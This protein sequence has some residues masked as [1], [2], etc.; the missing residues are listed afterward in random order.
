MSSKE[1]VEKSLKEVQDSREKQREKKRLLRELNGKWQ[2][3]KRQKDPLSAKTVP[4]FDSS[5]PEMLRYLKEHGYVVVKSVLSSKDVVKAKNLFW[6]FL[7]DQIGAKRGNMDSLGH[8][9]VRFFC[10]SLYIHTLQSFTSQSDRK[11]R[12]SSV[13]VRIIRIVRGLFER[14]HVSKKRSQIY[15]KRTIYSSRSTR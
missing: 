7:S 3:E 15:V 2:K 12:E 8:F 9:G 14:D 5:D 1:S 10:Y 6:E 13:L 11:Q 4:R